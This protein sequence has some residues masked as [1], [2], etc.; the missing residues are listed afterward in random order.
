MKEHNGGMLHQ[1]TLMSRENTRL[2]EGTKLE[3]LTRD[4]YHHPH[5]FAIPLAEEKKATERAVASEAWPTRRKEPCDGPK[6]R[7]CATPREEI[8]EENDRVRSVSLVGRSCPGS[9]RATTPGRRSQAKFEKARQTSRRN[10][11][12][13]QSSAV[14][15]QLGRSNYRQILLG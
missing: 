1:K 15:H 11:F 5:S 2:R 14:R 12:A 13:W 10:L 8:P 6:D 9:E 3:T 4:K 7:T